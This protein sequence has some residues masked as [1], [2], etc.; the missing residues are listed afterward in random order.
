MKDLITDLWQS[1]DPLCEDG[2]QFLAD[3]LLSIPEAVRKGVCSREG[4][5]YFVYTLN[6]EPVR[7]K[8]RGIKDKKSQFT[9]PMTDEEKESFKMPF[10]SQSKAPWCSYLVITEGELDSVV[11]SQL[12]VPNCVSLP[13]GA[14]SV[15]KTFRNNYEFL[16]QFDTIYIAFDMDEQGEKAAEKALSMLSPQKFRRICFPCKDAN[17]WIMQNPEVSINDFENLMANARKVEDTCIKNMH[18]L[19]DRYFKAVN[20]GISSG[21]Y[22]IDQLLGGIR[23]GEVTVVS[24]DTGSGKSTFCMNLMKNLSDRGQGIWINSYEMSPEMVVRKFASLI[25]KTRMKFREFTEDEVKAFN[26][27]L[28]SRKCYINDVNNKVDIDILR[29][30]FEMA[31]LVYDV[32]YILLDHLDYIYANGK[33]KTTLENIDE[34]VRAIHS[35]AMEFQVGV[36]LVVHPT[37]TLDGKEVTMSDL[38]GSS[39]IKQYADNILIVTRMSRL[40]SCDKTRVKI[41]VFKNRLQGIEGEVFLHYLPQEDGYTETF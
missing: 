27:Y 29:K 22:S 20:L 19:P 31:S 1:R 6:G 9:S 5:I 30:Q 33:K 38:K 24:A 34:A 39:S 14:S 10:F 15:E 4:K 8:A 32:K 11:L 41:R 13:N 12:G 3:R 37:K 23:V 25:L 16:Q 28:I 35:L 40:G 2:R 26:K 36:I 18:G 17:D 21:W 7:W